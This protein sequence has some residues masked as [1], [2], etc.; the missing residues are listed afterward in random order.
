M[1]EDPFDDIALKQ[2][3]ELKR[4]EYDGD[5]D[6]FRLVYSVADQDRIEGRSSFGT[7]GEYIPMDEEVVLEFDD[8]NEAAEYHFQDYHDFR[9]GEDPASREINLLIS[10]IQEYA[11][12]KHQEDSEDQNFFSLS[13]DQIE[14]RLTGEKTELIELADGTVPKH[15]M[16]IEEVFEDVMERYA[17]RLGKETVAELYSPK[18]A[19]IQV[20][21]DPAREFHDLSVS[22]EDVPDV[23]DVWNN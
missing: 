9:I 17:E 13:N 20:N 23:E 21:Y 18:D 22:L 1:D 8:P 5:E 19:G 12:K 16:I 10:S 3:S 7:I 11:R 2:N 6:V 15:D 14:D 4:T